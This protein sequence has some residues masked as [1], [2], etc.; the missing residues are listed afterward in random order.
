M[1]V[2]SIN[3]FSALIGIDWADQ[4]HDVCE[5]TVDDDKPAHLSTITSRPEAIHEWAMG[6]RARHD[7]KPVAVAC[8]LKKGPLIYALL[9]YEFITIF[10][11]HPATVAKMRKAFHPS[12]AKSDPADAQLQAELLRDYMHKLTPIVPDSAAVRALAQLVECRRKL[13]Q[14]RVDLTNSLT[15][16]LKNYYPQVLDWFNEKDS[17]VF[18]D[19][20]TKWPSLKQVKRARKKTL[21]DFMH[22]HNV[23][24][25]DVIEKRFTDIKT[26]I[27]LTEDE[28]V[29][30]PNQLMAELEANQ[31]KVLLQSIERIEQEINTR[32]RAM[33]DRKI[34][35]SFP[36]AGPQFAPRLLVAFGSE[37]N[38]YEDA[39]AMQK[40]AGIA[41]VVE[42]SGT[43]SW[44]HWRYACPKFLRQTFVEWAG[45]TVRY[46]FWARAYY[47]QQ[48]SRGKAHNTIIRSLAF[49]WIRIMFR[50]W[51]EQKPYDESK[52]LE[53]LKERG[54][55][56]LKF[57]VET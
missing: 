56:L 44:T 21:V 12:G 54:S 7:N 51:K 43:R 50:C 24:Y 15:Y 29:V 52:Y 22:Q 36:G 31:L 34:F 25:A 13:V 39:S 30:V 41:P 20:I 10:P 57:A 4:K 53:A 48:K 26:A 11:L 55:P 35:D 3:D 17:H 16:Y 47:D 1:K 19:F 28:G 2:F 40:Y 42:S 37:R 14:D 9:K 18:C 6:L 5:L 33:A 49:K 23:R 45:Q 38:R 27:P 8:E 32:Y 46:S